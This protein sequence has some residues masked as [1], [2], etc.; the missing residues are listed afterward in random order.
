MTNNINSILIN[1]SNP[2]IY[3]SY[4]IDSNSFSATTDT[5]PFSFG[6][7]NLDYSSLFPTNGISSFTP[8]SGQETYVPYTEESLYTHLSKNFIDVIFS[9]SYSVQKT[10][11]GNQ[12]DNISPSN[13]EFSYITPKFSWD[14]NLRILT[15]ANAVSTTLEPTKCSIWVSTESNTISKIEI[16]EKD[17]KETASIDIGGAVLDISLGVNNPN[18]YSTTNEYL[19]KHSINHYANIT[20]ST[21]DTVAQKLYEVKYVQD[22]KKFNANQ[23]IILYQDDNGVWSVQSYLGNLVK[24]NIDTL[25]IENIYYGF[26]SPHKIIWSDYHRCYL[27]AGNNN[28]WR[29][30]DNMVDIIYSIENYEIIDIACSDNGYL[31][32]I[33]RGVD[34][35]I[36]RVVKNDFFSIDINSY[37]AINTVNF[38][39]YCGGYLFYF[40]KEYNETAN[41]T[42]VA[43]SIIYNTELKTLVPYSIQTEIK[44]K[45]VEKVKYSGEAIIEVVYPNGGETIVNN[46][47]LDIQWYSSKSTKD[48]VKIDLLKEDKFLLSIVESTENNGTYKWEIPSFI[49]VS[50]DY[51]VSITWITN[52]PDALAEEKGTSSTAFIIS[53]VEPEPTQ[54]EKIKADSLQNKK[55][56][57]IGYD[58]LTNYVI[59]VFS[60]GLVG[61]HDLNTNSFLGLFDS[62]VVNIGSMVVLNERISD[63]YKSEK[64][65]L[66]VGSEPHLADKWD[67]GVVETS[68]N[69]MYYGGGNN[70]QAGTKYYIN[71]Q[72]YSS[73]QGWSEV[74]TKEFVMP[75]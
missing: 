36:I 67:S 70:L 41:N 62:K 9:N 50:N 52:K 65:R 68:L 38:V 26:D 46:S 54:E 40:L 49:G 32:I 45:P 56:V 2:L 3:F 16:N 73:L 71:I 30:K 31:A 13:H 12:A 47:E 75:F 11:V 20:N 5:I 53:D 27:I 57:A 29:L 61:Y 59:I 4:K 18:L 14:T 10:L 72:V 21:S 39:S 6:G 43:D 74:Q 19:Y 66:F 55:A 58:I 24:R 48:L 7:K 15:N 17:A 1:Q 23:D 37:H 35:D 64:V 28:I 69:S 25:E 63:F 60:N 42:Y 44:E 22:V 51:K 33:F 8:S 34:R